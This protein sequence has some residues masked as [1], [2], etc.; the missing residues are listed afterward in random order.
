[1][2]TLR[3]I[4]WDQLNT[5]ISSLNHAD[6]QHDVIFMC[7]TREEC[8]YVKHH[9]KKLVFLISAMR[10]FANE[11]VKQ[12]YKVNYVKL[13][14]PQNT[15]SMMGEIKRIV[16]QVKPD[17]ISITWPGEYRLLEL[18]QNLQNEIPIKLDILEDDRFLLSREEFKN[19]AKDKKALRM[20]Y[21]Y[22]EM[23]K[24]Y[25]ILMQNGR[26]VGGKWNYDTE[27]RHFPKGALSIP[28]YYQNEAD[29]ITKDVIRLVANY[30]QDHLGEIEPFH[31]AVTRHQAL[32]AL[33]VFIKKRLPLFG[34][35][36]DVMIQNEPWLYH[37]LISFYLN[38]GLI[39]PLECIHAIE[40]SYYRGQ[41]SLSSAEGFIRQILGW[42][43]FVRGIYWLKMPDYKSSNF[44]NASRP[45]P[46][47]YWSANTRM[48]CIKQC[49]N[50]TKRNAYA[51]HIQ[52]LMVLGNFALLAGIDP[53]AVN[54]W[55][56]IVYAD[57]HEWVELPN[58]TGM[59]LFSDGG[60]LSS[61]PYSA[62]GAYINKMSNYCQG[63]TYKVKEK[64]G[65]DACPFNY[66]YWDFL[67]RHREKLKNNQRLKMAYASLLKMNAVKIKQIQK[68]ALA[69]FEDVEKT[70]D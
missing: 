3:I 70:Y 28:D 26:P 58:V 51:H 20:E 6:I 4:L 56:L 15:H 55:Y 49:V 21:F 60:Y 37:S 34:D 53:K 42:R 25:F 19:W 48:N 40:K 67:I 18:L 32:V 23:R 17:N 66:L 63:C 47:F 62:S 46:E 43:E 41:A 10:H 38:I 35:Y 2:S 68:D 9:K 16:A 69:F 24:K 7:E 14:D 33:Q 57:A 29:D 30:F 13:D 8:T 50:D 52:R 27:N 11:L 31:Y 45:L 1:M 59:I 54:E 44:L 61:K 36:Q 65:Q 22:R 5:N 64:N 39:N 12:G